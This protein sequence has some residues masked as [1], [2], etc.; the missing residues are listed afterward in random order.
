MIKQSGD[1]VRIVEIEAK[2]QQYINLLKEVNL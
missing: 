2:A 1:T